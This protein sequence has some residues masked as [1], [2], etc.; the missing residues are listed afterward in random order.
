[1][2]AVKSSEPPEEPAFTTT[3]SAPSVARSIASLRRSRSS[4]TGA[5]LLGS[6]PHSATI[7]ASIRLLNSM[8]WPGSGEAPTGTNSVP[9]GM[10]ATLG[11]RRTGTSASPAAAQAATSW[12]LSLWL[13]GNSSSVATMS[14]PTGR[15]C[16]YGGTG[17]WSSIVE[18]ST[19]C[20]TSTMITASNPSGTG[21]PVSSHTA[22]SPTSSR[23]GE[24]SVAPTVSRDRTATPSIA[25]AS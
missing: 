25:A 19:S 7:A 15:T 6:P 4:G 16:W 12:G 20:T 17:D 1:M 13:C 18:P 2:R 3:I 21:S 10:S 8:I 22:C 23:T 14:S 5:C 24:V 9:V 11:A